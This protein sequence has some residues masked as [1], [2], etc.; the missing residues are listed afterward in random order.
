MIFFFLQRIHIKIK[1]KIFFGG[2]GGA[3]KGGGSGGWGWARVSKYFF[4]LLLLLLLIIIMTLFIVE[5]QLDNIQSSL[6]SSLQNNMY[7]YTNKTN[8]KTLYKHITMI[9]I[10]R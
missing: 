5:A 8:S 10:K 4:L 6:R 7:I 9:E 1:K 2:G 3:G